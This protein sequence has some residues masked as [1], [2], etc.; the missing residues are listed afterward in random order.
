MTGEIEPPKVIRMTNDFRVRS[1]PKLITVGSQFTAQFAVVVNLTVQDGG[2][3][4]VG[5]EGR[6]R[7][8]RDIDDRQPPHAQD[9]VVLQVQVA[10]IWAAVANLLKHLQAERFAFLRL[11]IQAADNPTHRSEE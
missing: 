6:L 5:A 11:W 3:G 2:D 9:H 7:S 4:A 10:G 1:V 8:V